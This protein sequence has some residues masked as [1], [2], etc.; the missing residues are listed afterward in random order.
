MS[1]QTKTVK[2]AEIKQEQAEQAAPIEET[3]PMADTATAEQ[4]QEGTP[5]EVE[6]TGPVSNTITS[7]DQRPAPEAPEANAKAILE[8]KE[9]LTYK[10]AAQYTGFAESKIRG[11]VKT[12]PILT[13]E[14][15]VEK[16]KIE[17]TDFEVTY[18]KLSALKEW[19]ESLTR[20]NAQGVQRNKATGTK[21][22]AFIR[23][24]QI[25]QVEAALSPMGI[26][27]EKAYQPKPAT[28]APAEGAE[29]PPAAEQAPAEGE[30]T[31]ADLFKPEQVKA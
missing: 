21:Y 30:V 24:D 17:G 5:A 26:T 29:S 1:K 9:V 12:S 20:T 19:S 6:I 23:Q 11:A 13:A 27:L 7:L 2:A 4:E 31:M 18:I 15:A 22:F 14:G 16:R 8:A 28:E 25:A 3:N 10:Q